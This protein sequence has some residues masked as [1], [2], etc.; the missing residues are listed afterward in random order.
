MKRAYV[1]TI[2]GA[3][4]ACGALS[5]QACGGDD[6]NGSTTHTITDSGSGTD[7]TTRFHRAVSCQLAWGGRGRRDQRCIYDHLL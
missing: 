6:N 5:L 7:S 1:V 3:L 2:L 4:A